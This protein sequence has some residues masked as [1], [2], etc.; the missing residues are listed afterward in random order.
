M[1][2][3]MLSNAHMQHAFSTILSKIDLTIMMLH[4]DSRFTRKHDVMIFLRASSS[5]SNTVEGA[6]VYDRTSR[7]SEPMISKLK[8][9]GVVNVIELLVQA[10]VSCI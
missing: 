2:Q 5:L 8:I 9:H 3:M 6:S 7:I 4:T 10:L 1:S